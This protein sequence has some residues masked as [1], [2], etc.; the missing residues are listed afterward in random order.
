MSRRGI[1]RIARMRLRPVLEHYDY[2][3]GVW[4]ARSDRV[5]SAQR[6]WSDIAYSSDGGRVWACRCL[7]PHLSDD[8]LKALLEVE[9]HL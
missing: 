7:A 4:E 6:Q 2:T 8:T 5:R 3:I 1:G 9:F